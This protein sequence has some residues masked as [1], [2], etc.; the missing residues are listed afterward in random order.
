MAQTKSTSKA[1]K[2]KKER[3][4]SPYGSTL[5]IHSKNPDLTK[6]QVVAQL[7]AKK[8]DT[9]ACSGAIMTGVAQFKKIYKLLGQNGHLK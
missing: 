1:T 2:P 5:E 8:F 3:K 9:E 7:K 6:A 4:P